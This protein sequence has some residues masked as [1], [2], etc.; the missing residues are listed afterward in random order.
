MNRK[1]TINVICNNINH[2]LLKP[3]LAG[4]EEE[5]IPVQ[6]DFRKEDDWVKAAYLAAEESVLGVGMAL[7]ENGT[8][9]IHYYRLNE[10]E[11]LFKRNQVDSSLAKQMGINAAR[12]V[13][14][15]PFDLSL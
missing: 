15:K 11:P 12:L 4:I 10:N 1:P 13:K 6:T 5:G 9:I 7:D 3:V 8:V 2:P 14:G